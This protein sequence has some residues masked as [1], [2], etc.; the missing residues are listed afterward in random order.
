MHYVS[1]KLTTSAL[2]KQFS[3]F[4]GL[5]NS[6]CEAASSDNPNNIAGAA[7]ATLM[8]WYKGKGKPRVWRTLVDAFVHVDMADYASE[9]KEKI[10]KDQLIK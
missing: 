10:Q 7:L 3:L 4:I 2:L 9:L 8:I 6:D 1:K 5:D